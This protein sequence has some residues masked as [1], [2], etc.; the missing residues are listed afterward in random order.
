ME[1]GGEL[2][3]TQCVASWLTPVGKA[4]GSPRVSYMH[5]VAIGIFLARLCGFPG[6]SLPSLS[7]G[8]L[9]TPLLFT[10][11]LCPHY[12][13][14]PCCSTKEHYVN[15]KLL[16][17]EERHSP[18]LQRNSRGGEKPAC[19]RIEWLAHL[20]LSG[21]PLAPFC[22]FDACACIGDSYSSMLAALCRVSGVCV[23]PLFSRLHVSA[24]DERAFILLFMYFVP[25][26]SRCK[27]QPMI[28]MAVSSCSFMLA[29]A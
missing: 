12:L 15:R 9:L 16:V 10:T 22:L 7:P 11:L 28:T 4:S 17:V 20:H 24:E 5:L 19:G 1:D 27:K 2:Y 21:L 29:S 6:P 14:L 13:Y 8:K 26:S 3:S 25:R 23:P 18:M